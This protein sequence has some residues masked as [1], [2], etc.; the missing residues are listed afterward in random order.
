MGVARWIGAPSQITEQLASDVS[1]QMLEEVDHL[2]AIERVVLHAQQQSTTRGDAADDGQVVTGEREA[3]RWW[4]AAWRKAADHRRQ[5]GKA[6]FV[7]PN[8]GAPFS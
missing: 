7:Y 6:R 4:V 1:Q 5:Q 8:D 2:G 3:Q